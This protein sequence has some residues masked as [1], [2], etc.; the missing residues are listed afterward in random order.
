MQSAT[1]HDNAA[2]LPGDHVIDGYVRVRGARENNLRNVD[3]DVPRDSIVAFTGV[4]GSGKSSLAFGTIYAEAQRRYFESVAPYARRLIQQGHNPKVELISGL[5]PAVAL[6]QRRGAPSSRSSVGTVTTLSNSL[7]MLFSR[8]G[9]YP[10]G[11]EQLDSDAFSPNTAA[12][13]CQEC[14]GLGV[15]HTVS[16]D[17]LVPDNTL[18]IR[19]GAVAAWPGAWQGKNLRDILSHLG[20]DVD[21][22]W[23]KLPRKHRDWILFTDEQPVVEVTPERDRVAK[24]YKGRFWSAKKY[25]QH[26]LADSQSAPMRERALAFMES[27]PCARCGGTGLRAE[28]LA[29]TFAGR[30]IA[31]LN[32][33]PMVELAEVIRPTAGLQKAGT[34]SRRQLSGE[35]NEV[36]VA[37]TADLLAR[38]TV[39][40]GLG[41]GYL[42]LGRATPSLSPGEMQRLRIA[43]QLRSGL[44]GVIYVLDEPSAGLHPADAE[45]LLAVLDQLKASGNSV[46]VVEHNMDVV[47]RAD[48][49]VDVG[50]GAGEGGGEV[51]YSGPVA[52]LAA[53]EESVTRPFL[54]DDGDVA[55]VSGT[56]REPHAWLELSDVSRHN[57][58]GLDARFPLGVFTAVTG[59]S[60]SG[61][62][63]LVSHVLGEVVGSGLQVTQPSQQ[64]ETDPAGPL[65]VGE[66]SGA[67]RIDRLVTV[68][69][70]PI[71]RTPRSNLATYTGLF[72]AVRKVFAATDEAKARGFGAGRF[73]FNVAGGRCEICQGEGFVAVELLFLPG[74]Y[75]PCPEC[76]GSRY[77][78]ETLGVTYRG[79]NVAEVLRLTVDAAAEFLADVPAAAR[80]LKSLRDVG[81]G[82]LRLGQPATELSGGEAQRIKLATELQRA[83][84]GHT[85][86]LLDEPT[87]GLHPADVEL[88][89]T[90]LHGLVDSGNTVI[91]VEHEMAV[92]ARADWVIDLGPSGGDEGGRIVAAGTASDVA[93]SPHSRTAPYLAAAL[94]SI[95]GN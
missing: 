24:P 66:V 91:V 36:A 68:D 56:V 34:A 44:F 28:A 58:K 52:G 74:S 9:T 77:N 45:P 7:R 90:Q 29:V 61:K 83:R 32:A 50:P 82:Y 85:L 21:T 43:T 6:Q 71:G 16:E 51:L 23:N 70:K 42:A 75:G 47:R 63:T 18:T 95:R 39:L 78:G 8:A 4:S 37:I 62:S 2:G 88:L 49:L 12:G 60:G 59:V 11:S 93:R 26:T 22:P 33:M 20:Y 92:V 1:N 84:R 57:L 3:V 79:K 55:P 25:V 41:L 69:Q 67:G 73:S 81:L 64:D 89:M 27:G 65:T 86:Y 30:S 10:A 31:E 53:I 19:E 5:P 35:E 46:F 54:F 13:A 72:D 87:T 76:G 14:H 40:L 80:S 48:W 38:I 17:S 15:A 94:E